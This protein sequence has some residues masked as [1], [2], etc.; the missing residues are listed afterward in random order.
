[1]NN[2][3]KPYGIIIRDEADVAP[4]EVLLKLYNEFRLQTPIL[5]INS[6]LRTKEI[7]NLIIKRN[8]NNKSIHSM[9]HAY[10]SI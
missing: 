8:E 10:H 6:E 3:K 1:M 5:A 7:N 4:P 9:H 2:G